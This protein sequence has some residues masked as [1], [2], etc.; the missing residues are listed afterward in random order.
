MIIAL[1]VLGYGAQA[2]KFK[3]KTDFLKGQTEFSVEFDFTGMTLDGDKEADYIKKRLADQKT[4]ED[5]TKWKENWDNASNEW[6]SFFLQDANNT[7]KGKCK[8]KRDAETDYTIHIKVKDVDPGNFAGPFSN[9]AKID[10]VVT[11]T[12]TGNDQVLATAEFK[13]VYSA[14]GLTPIE[15]HRIKMSFGRFGDELA[16]LIMKAIK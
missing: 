8:F 1:L 15:S 9:P 7:T 13:D 5:K 12:K 10:A 2:Q 6:I 11:I 4:D 3:P 16:E 14:I